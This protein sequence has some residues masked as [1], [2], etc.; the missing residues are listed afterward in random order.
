MA[1]T[2]ER[3]VTPVETDR[4]K[5]PKPLLHYYD[6]HGNPLD[7]PVLVWVD[8]DTISRPS[9]APVYPALTRLDLGVN[10]FDGVAMLAGQSYGSFDA[11]ISLPIFNW[12]VPCVDVGVGVL[13]SPPNNGSYTY[14]G[15][16]SP[17]FK[18]GFD[19]NFLYRSKQDYRAGVGF[20]CGYSHRWYSAVYGEIAAGLMVKVAGPFSMGWSLRYRFMFHTDKAMPDGWFVPGYGARN[21]SL[22]ATFS[23]YYTLPLK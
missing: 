15:K 2:R 13:K 23:L 18:I 19:Y 4:Q 14:T 7:E 5:P 22:A 3:T 12:I 6:R 21:R 8:T 10:I 9:A 11:S 17:Y 1:Q 20:R 16:A